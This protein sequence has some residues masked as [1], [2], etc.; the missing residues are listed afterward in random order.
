MSRVEMRFLTD[1]VFFVQLGVLLVVGFVLNWI[2]FSTRRARALRSVGLGKRVLFFRCGELTYHDEREGTYTLRC[3]RRRC[4][5]PPHTFSI[6]H[7]VYFVDREVEMIDDVAD[8]EICTACKG[9]GIIEHIPCSECYGSGFALT[10][11]CDGGDTQLEGGSHR[12]Y[13][14]LNHPSHPCYEETCKFAV[15][16]VHFSQEGRLLD[17]RSTDHPR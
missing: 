12:D 6:L 7:P 8:D 13:C 4:H 16:E 17:E 2:F 1:Q 10:C 11:S 3:M 15:V 9:T 5:R 14:E